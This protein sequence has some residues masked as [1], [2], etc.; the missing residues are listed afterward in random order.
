MITQ[1]NLVLLKAQ[2]QS[3][4]DDGG[5][6]PT[7]HAVP[8]HT[9]N[10]LFPDVS[11]TDRMMGRVRLRKIFLGVRTANDEL[12][13]SARLIFTKIPDKMSVFAFKA[14]S[15][16]D[17][18]THAKNR[19]ESYLSRGSRWSG[20]LLESHLKGQRIIQ[21]SLDESDAIPPIGSSLV[22]IQ[23]EN[24]SDEYYQF[25]RVMKVETSVR[26]FY[27]DSQKTVNRLIASC[28]LTDALRYDFEG[29]SVGEFIG[30]AGDKRR[31]VV[32]DT[33]VANASQYYSASHLAEPITAMTT[34]SIRLQS[35]FVQVV[36]STQ[37]ETPL[38]QNNIAGNSRLY[39]AG[40]EAVTLTINTTQN[41][42][43]GTIVPSSLTATIGG[44]VYKDVLGE[45]KNGNTIA[46]VMDYETGIISWNVPSREVTLKF[47]P[48]GTQTGVT[49]TAVIKVP[50]VGAGFNYV[51]TL[52][53]TPLKG[54]VNVSYQ[55]GGEIY[56]ISEMGGQGT[57]NVNDKTLVITTNAIADSESLI[58]ISYGTDNGAISVGGIVKPLYSLIK[59][60]KI[61]LTVSMGGKGLNF[62][63]IDGGIR[64]YFDQLPSKGEMLSLKGAV[65]HTQNTGA[66]ES[67]NSLTIT[68]D[69]PIAKGTLSIEVMGVLLG[70]DGAGNVVFRQG[71]EKQLVNQSD[72]TGGRTPTRTNATMLERTT[73]AIGEVVGTVDYISRTIII[74]KPLKVQTVQT[75]NQ[76]T[77][78]DYMLSR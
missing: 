28:E 12:V 62:D 47:T 51:H 1:D 46:G 9:S 2:N 29:L 78:P 38:V 66:V 52:P 76:S 61:P 73:N 23:N 70:D 33:F 36:P 10:A 7:S 59:T 11:D 5:G 43:I 57:L 30:R 50:K 21:L 24:Q 41:T 44:A 54:S 34:Q 53:Q 58:I 60:D 63:V 18:R 68:L 25:V 71:Y 74:N 20:H 3:D 72:E 17:K 26:K 49:A 75:Q 42:H 27:I 40:G 67:N 19:I 64:V 31:A 16:A 14:S 37:I 8:N 45:I 15:F 22:L 39:V 56:H 48:A 32:R 69:N 55:A 35:T 6:L 65:G 13:Q 77:T 4:F